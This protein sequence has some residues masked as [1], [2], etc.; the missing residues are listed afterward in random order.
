M[1]DRDWTIEKVEEGRGYKSDAEKEKPFTLKMIVWRVKNP[2]NK[3]SYLIFAMADFQRDYFPFI[4]L[5]S[6]LSRIIE[7]LIQMKLAVAVDI[8][9]V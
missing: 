3:G 7:D 8:G 2:V 9:Q 4:C 5:P 6:R 1:C